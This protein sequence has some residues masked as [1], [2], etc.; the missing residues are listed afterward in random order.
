MG[1]LNGAPPEGHHRQCR[2]SSMVTK[3]RCRR[4]A[5]T[6]RDY[7]ACHGGKRALANNQGLPKHYTKHLGQTLR[8]KIE[9]LANESHNEQVHLYEELALARVLLEQAVVLCEPALIGNEMPVKVKVLA[10][11]ALADGIALVKDL[12]VAAAKIENDTRDKVSM[13]VLD[14]FVLQLLRAVYRACDDDKIADRIEFE[15]RD[16]VSLPSGDQPLEV[17]AVEGTE[18]T[19]D[20]VVTAMDATVT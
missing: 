5:L 11:S 14:L 7:C 8:S 3:K 15:I 18:I 13:R 19:P 6:G 17:I 9:D 4:W 16:S 12:V 1:N 10:M 2:A 20:A